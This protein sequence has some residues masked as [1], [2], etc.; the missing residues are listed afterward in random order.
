MKSRYLASACSLAVLM[1]ALPAMARIT[2]TESGE[3]YLVNVGDGCII[4]VDRHGREKSS[5]EQCSSRDVRD[6]EEAVDDYRDGRHKNSDRYSSSSS[7]SHG[8]RKN[9]EIHG[10][11]DNKLRIW[12]RP[13]QD[14]RVVAGGV[15]NG[16]RVRGLGDCERHHGEEWCE[17]E[18]RGDKGWVM[19][20]FL[21]ETSSG[22]SHSSDR[23]RSSG[24]DDL[25]DLKDMRA[26][27][28][29]DELEDMGYRYEKR[30][31]GKNG[32]IEYWWNRSDDQCI[33]VNVKDGHYVALT[34]QPEVMC[35]K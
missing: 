7:S 5:T 34:K 9:Y 13:S 2:V 14:S 3:N 23:H 32:D 35:G 6:A 20:K 11:S 27:R 17:V 29:E 28:G 31:E 12:D 24:S 18:Y 1:T 33:A 16:E 8:G 25:Q 10:V 21:R 26:S 15:H 30:I 22:S 4:V 19:Q